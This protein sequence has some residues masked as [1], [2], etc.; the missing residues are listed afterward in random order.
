M[1]L[2]TGNLP[3]SGDVP[4]EA[5]AR[6]APYVHATHCKDSILYHTA[7]G[8]VQQLRSVGE[9]VVNWEAALMVLGQYSPGLHLSFEDYRAENLIKMDDP[10]WRE[11]FPEMTAADVG[12]FDQLAAE[13]EGWIE[14]GEIMDVETYNELPFTDADR[15]ASYVKGAEYIRNI[16]RKKGL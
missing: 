15:L 5:I 11:H 1:T 12:A 10:A 6:L 14:R 13:C 8:I 7:E 4:D 16:L 9:G 3:L 2:D